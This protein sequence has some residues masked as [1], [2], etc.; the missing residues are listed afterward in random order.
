[1]VSQIAVGR[2]RCR[3]AR[4]RLHVWRARANSLAE[5]RLGRSFLRSGH[6]AGEVG[7][8]A[9]VFFHVCWSAPTR[10]GAAGVDGGAGGVGAA[11]TN[12]GR[13]D[14]KES[15]SAPE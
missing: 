10:R 9:H 5:A 2:G 15:W 14:Q 13:R 7:D 6:A 4:A 8:E 11:Q 12:G 1:M 3:A